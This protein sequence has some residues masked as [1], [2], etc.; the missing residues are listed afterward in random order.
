[1]EEMEH[2]WQEVFVLESDGKAADA[3][4]YQMNEMERVKARY[5]ANKKAYEDFLAG[6]TAE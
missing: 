2:V 5:D 6:A 3:A 4:E 1:M